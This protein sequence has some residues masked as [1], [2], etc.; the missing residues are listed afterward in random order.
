VSELN[1]RQALRLFAALGAAGAAAPLLSACS[2]GGADSDDNEPNV[3]RS[4]PPIKLGMVVPQTGSLK[5]FGDDMANGFQL[6]LKQNGNKLGGRQVT[7]VTVDEGEGGAAGK[8]AVEKLIK[9]DKVLALTGIVSP[10]TMAEARDLIESSQVPLIGSNASPTNLNGVYIWRTSFIPSEP[11]EALGQ[12]V[13]GKIGDG[14]VAVV[15]GDYAGD[16]D[17]IKGF[18]DALIAANGRLAFPSA[19]LTAPGT[20][21]Y[22]DVI[23]QVKSS[24][25][26]AMFCFYTGTN[27]VDFVKAVKSAGFGSNFGIYAPGSLTEGPLLK[28]QGDSARGIFTAMNYSPDLTNPAN[29]RFIADY[30]KAYQQVIPTSYAVASYDAAMVIDKALGEVSGDLSSQQLN[31]AL[32]RLG[33]M[34]SPRG[35]WQFTANRAPLQKWY[36]RQVRNDGTV[37]SNV[38]TAELTTLG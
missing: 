13:A 25:A 14:T 36:L 37:L 17:E 5:A 18:T 29:R 35:S 22:G 30:Q 10:A 9:N 2:D 31:A 16:H 34:D 12:W 3:V 27:A 24:G 33:Q 6:Y 20:R 26:S 4:G 21:N 19:K 8:T 38:L 28:Q 11:S 1:R 15:G 32:G 7:L 23:Q